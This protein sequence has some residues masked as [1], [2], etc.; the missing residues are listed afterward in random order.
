MSIT[1]IMTCMGRR[2]HLELTLPFA[3]QA[4]DKVIV[5]DW[6]CPQNRGEFAASEG[7]SV[8]YK[9][10]ERFF[11]AA[12]ARNYGV[13]M[14]VSDYIAFAD[15]D[16]LCMPGLKEELRRT[17]A[18]SRMVLSARDTEGYDIND[19]VGFLVCR[20]DS[21]WNVGGYDEHWVGWGSEDIQL[22]GKLL[23]DEKLEVVRLSHMA[24]GALAHGN[25]LR[26]QYRDGRIED[27]AIPNFHILKEW[28]HNKGVTDFPLNPLVHDIAVIGRS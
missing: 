16:V 8:V 12:K 27:T 17:V 10:G 21:F 11:S 1:A 19:T 25:D 6:S 20:T 28:F 18:K 15:A 9:Y 24:L 22:R 23:L 5:V 3:L 7:A 26:N 2:E 14:V 13:K 4:F